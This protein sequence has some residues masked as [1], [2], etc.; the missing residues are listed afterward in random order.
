M[1]SWEQMKEVRVIGIRDGLEPQS[2]NA[3]FPGQRD[4]PS[5]GLFSCPAA[6]ILRLDQACV[7]TQHLL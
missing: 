3:S 7:A 1:G 6:Q 4:V 5:E 2:C